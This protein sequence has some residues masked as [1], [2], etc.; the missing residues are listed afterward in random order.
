MIDD[1]LH[2]TSVTVVLIGAETA[3]R[4]YV[5]YEIIQSH[6]RGNGLL[7]VYIHNIEDQHGK[8]DTQ[9]GNPFTHLRI[10]KNGKT[11]YLSELYPTYHWYG[12][13][14]YNN[15]GT[16]IEKAARATGR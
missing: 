7:G 15:L 8:M 9:G 2:N 6:N 10:E 12:D 5:D 4:E 13:D 3:N 14:G 1:G 11:V 16:W